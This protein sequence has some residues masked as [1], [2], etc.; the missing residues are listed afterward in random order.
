VV[1]DSEILA[2]YRLIAS[3]GIFAEPAS[4]ASVAG[5]L[6]YAGGGQLKPG[7]VIVCTLTGHGLKD[8]DTALK[9]LSNTIVVEPDINKVLKILERE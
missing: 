3:G 7:S 1:T 9:N 8:P 4:A 2:A 6:K 5:L